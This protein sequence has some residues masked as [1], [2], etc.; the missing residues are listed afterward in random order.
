ME[1]SER[2]A[3]SFEEAFQLLEDVVGC[4]EQGGLSLEETLARFEQGMH[5][6]SRCLQ[7]LDDAE[8]RVTRLLADDGLQSGAE[9]MDLESAAD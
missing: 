6:A 7:L 1:S 9:L 5:L 4:L 3:A 2:P 8:L